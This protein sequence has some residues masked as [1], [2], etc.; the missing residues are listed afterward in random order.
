MSHFKIFP[1]AHIIYNYS[2]NEAPLC[3]PPPPTWTRVGGVARA[4][5]APLPSAHQPLYL[6]TYIFR[7][8]EMYFN[9][10]NEKLQIRQI[11]ILN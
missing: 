3:E 8:Y 5:N 7:I 11:V 4:P 10:I 1:Q 6:Y 2:I 9:T